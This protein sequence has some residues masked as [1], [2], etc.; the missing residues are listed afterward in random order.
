MSF[1]VIGGKVVSEEHG[2][3]ISGVSHDTDDDDDDTTGDTFDTS[4][5]NANEILFGANPKP[6]DAPDPMV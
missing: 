2:V 5:A 3:Q 4:S 1:P 6:H